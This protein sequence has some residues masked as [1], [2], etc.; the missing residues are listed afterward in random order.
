M[1]RFRTIIAY[2]KHTTNFLDKLPKKVR[3]KFLWT[4]QL[5]EEIERVP[6]T[7]LKH[8]QDGIYEVR[9]RL[10]SDTYRVMSFFDEEKLVLTINGFQKKTQKTPKK[11]ISKAKII[12]DEYYEEK[13][14]G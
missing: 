7:Y 3:A 14:R 8:V 12:R 10:G 11:E 2:K 6:D 4:F 1:E 9:V 13:E 5:I